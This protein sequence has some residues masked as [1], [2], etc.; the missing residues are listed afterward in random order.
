MMKEPYLLLLYFVSVA[1]AGIHNMGNDAAKSLR[2]V[3][4]FHSAGELLL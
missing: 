3:W 4:E 1:D 2:N